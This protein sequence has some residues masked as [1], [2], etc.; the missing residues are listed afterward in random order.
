MSNLSPYQNFIAVSRYARW[1]DDENRRETWAETSERYITFMRNHLS[2]NYG[3]DAKDPIFKEVQTAITNLDIVPSMRAI[4]A[5]GAS[6]ERNPLAGYNCSFVTV[7]DTRVFDESMYVLMNGTGLGFSVEHRY[8][9]QLPTVPTALEESEEV[10]TVGDSKEG[11]AQAFRS[12]INELYSGRIVKWDVSGVRPAGARLKTFGGRASGP[13]PLIDLFNFTVG[14]FRAAQGRKL[15]PIECHDIMCKIGDIVVAGGVRRS[16]LISLSDLDDFAMAKAKSGNWWD[17]NVQRALANNS[18][19]YYERPSAAQFLREWRNL[20][21]SQS[22]ER[23]I[24]NLSGIR[25][26]SE[27]MTPDRDASRIVGT[28]PCAEISLRDMGLC[29]LSEVIL[30]E[31]DS[32]DDVKNKV[33]LASIVGTWQST[34]TDFPYL[35]AGWKSN[36]ED[37]RLLGVSLTGV[38]GHKKFNNP[39]DEG[40]PKRLESLRKVAHD[41]NRTEAARVGI[42]ISKAITTLKPS[43]TVSQLSLV[44]SGI[45]PWHSEYYTRTVRAS[46]DDPLTKLMQDAGVPNEVDAMK[47]ATSTVFSFPTKAP[48]GAVTRHNVTALEHLRLYAVYRTFYTDHNVSITVSVK[49]SEWVSVGAW[50]FDNWDS[51]GGVSFLPYTD[52]TYVQAPYQ[53]MTKEEYEIAIAAFPKEVRFG[54]LSFYETEDGTTGNQTLACTASGCEVVDLP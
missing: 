49:D 4:M 45:H 9:D 10:I 52:H 42:S 22:G 16:A 46:N 27:K 43:G 38:Y 41:T 40:L 34:L 29:N 54:D 5:A 30:R 53:D 20:I 19:T 48:E 28:N 7:N 1:L 15:S 12:I 11:W 24:F 23:G 25:A 36:A 33:R 44:S 17:N 26:H 6:L 47:P 51:V 39:N 32:V 31:T 2:A 18:A 3:Y 35:R 50:V 8:T 21:E 14:T 37:E 13:A